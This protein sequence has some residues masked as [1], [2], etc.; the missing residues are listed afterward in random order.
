MKEQTKEN[1][2]L[3]KALDNF[4]DSLLEIPKNANTLMKIS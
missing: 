4:V 2:Q 1:I 3:Q